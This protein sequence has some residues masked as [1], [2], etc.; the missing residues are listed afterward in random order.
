MHL[1]HRAV[2]AIAVP[3]TLAFV[4]TPLI[5]IVDTAIVGQLGDAA[6]IGGLAAGAIVFDLVFGTFNFLRSGTTGLIAQASGR[7]DFVEEQAILARALMIA[8]ACGL[9]IAI[10]GPLIAWV[11]RLF[12]AAEASVSAAMTDYIV[13][14]ALSTPFALANYALLGTLLGRG[15]SG[16]AFGLQIVVNGGNMSL[17]VL[18]GLVF[19]WGLEGVAWGTVAGE[20][21][22]FVA[23][24]L[25][26][27]AIYR[28]DDRPNLMRIMD[29]PAFSRLLALNRD[30]MIRTFA[31]LSAFALFTRAG[32]GLGTVQLAAN[33]VLLNFFLLGGYL[34]DG[35]ATAAER[36]VGHAVGG[37][38]RGPFVRAVK[39]TALWGF[40]L[41]FVLAALFYLGGETLIALMTTAPDVRRVADLWLPLAALTPI[42]GVLAFQMDGVFI[43]ATWGT[44][45]RNR[46][47]VSLALFVAALFIFT[48]LYGNAALWAS[49]HLFLLARGLLLLAALPAKMKEE[50]RSAEAGSPI[51]SS[52]GL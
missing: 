51:P 33:A 28:K 41:S 22:G 24:L 29:R 42:T 52:S 36:F 12:I 4:T 20:V 45:M 26:M 7:D 48:P 10:A 30:I 3:T 37:A 40:I 25:V 15:Q 17:S 39:L 49:L 21:I 47:L 8:I 32:A 31:L 5:G 50:F 19:G 18:F 6:L 43:G 35:F 38:R 11:G 16:T 46:M 44:S 9:L 27:A 14:R 2:F 23:G 13:I 1:T 34:L